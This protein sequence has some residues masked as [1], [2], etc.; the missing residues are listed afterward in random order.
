MNVLV[1]TCIWS[2]ALRKT[3]SQ[4]QYI[5]TRKELAELVR[6]SRVQII[7]AIRQE[8]LSGIRHRVQFDK[9]KKALS[10]FP[11]ISTRQEDHELAAELFNI[12]RKKGI[13]GSNTDFL[14]CAIALNHQLQIFTDDGDFI[15]FQ[16]HI[17]IKL[18]SGIY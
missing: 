9:L 11:D 13:Q 10:P 12:L 1:D 17:P 14:I 16:E 4:H 2:N 6:E 7:G 8:V 18:Y 15:S 5:Q 3:D